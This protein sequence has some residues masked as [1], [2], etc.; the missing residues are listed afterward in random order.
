MQRALVNMYSIFSIMQ[1]MRD[2]TNYISQN[3]LK[4]QLGC[5]LAGVVQWIE[6]GL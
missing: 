1:M 3:S 2:L 5:A 4:L 6:R